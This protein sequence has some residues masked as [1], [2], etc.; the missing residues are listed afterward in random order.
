MKVAIF[1]SDMLRKLYIHFIELELLVFWSNISDYNFFTYFVFSLAMKAMKTW[2]SHARQKCAH[3]AS[4]SSKKWRRSTRTTRTAGSFT[5]F[6]GVPCVNTWSTSSTNWSICPRSTW[7]TACLRI[8]PFSRY[9]SDT[10]IAFGCVN[11]CLH[12]LLLMFSRLCIR[13]SATETRKRRYCA[14]RTC[15]RCRRRSTVRNTT[16]TG[17]WKISGTAEDRQDALTSVPT[18]SQY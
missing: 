3:S 10:I 14:R 12:S 6:T 11:S 13:W 4:R 1:R 5:G 8:S 17:W 16:S 7:W 9:S 2:P 15:S 18:P